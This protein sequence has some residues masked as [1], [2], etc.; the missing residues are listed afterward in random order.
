MSGRDIPPVKTATK[1]APKKEA[2]HG[3]VVRLRESNAGSVIGALVGD[4]LDCTIISEGPGNLGDRHWYT[5][6]AIES[7][8]QVF[9]GAKAFLN[10]PT[11]TEMYDRPE[12]MIEDVI[13]FYHDLRTEAGADGRMKLKGKLKLT[14]SESDKML[15]LRGL[16]MEAAPYAV[17]YPGRVLFGISINANG[18]D[19]EGE[20]QGEP[21]NV[22]TR[23][24]EAFSA[25]VVTFPAAGGEF[26]EKL[27]A[28]REATK[29]AKAK[30]AKVKNKAL[31][32]A[33]KAHEDLMAA[34]DD[35]AKGAA[36]VNLKAALMAMDFM[37]PEEEK[38]VEAAPAAAAPVEAG[39]P[40]GADD[41]GAG[42][43]NDEA[44]KTE[45]S[46]VAR[47]GNLIEAAKAVAEKNPTLAKSLEAD[48]VAE[49]QRIVEFKA[50]RERARKA[51]AKN[52]LA[53][54]ATRAA[55]L[56]AES[57]LKPGQLAVELLVGL[58][59]AQQRAEISDRK[60]LIESLAADVAPMRS[61]VEGAGFR[62]SPDGE[63]SPASVLEAARASGLPMKAV[64]VSAK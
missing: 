44:E 20:I 29:Q 12:R 22:V 55:R 10:H 64:E 39:F 15:H 53:E 58:T 30:E 51:E 62:V 57:G 33:M 21:W 41:K 31:S 18:E 9:E 48:A 27:E 2:V 50:L 3:T 4:D 42:D 32:A 36:N 6:A 5:P 1:P 19:Q 8:V 34:G 59:E 16:L 47:K 26:G 63:G 43:D 37:Q 38:P 7:G 35:E 45:A 25:D 24:V 52:V 14:G 60:S 46:M 11:G 49:G 17:K 23:F 61:I 28:L 40:T 13:G 56:L 54:S